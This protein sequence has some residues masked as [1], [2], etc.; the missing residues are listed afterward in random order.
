MRI[1]ITDT[2]IRDAVVIQTA[3]AI[4]RRRLEDKDLT[5]WNL[6]RYILDAVGCAM[7]GDE[8]DAI[9]REATERADYIQDTDVNW[10][11]WCYLGVLTA[12]W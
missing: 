11:T 3:R 7:T 12:S 2:E 8:V 4:L 6:D 9:A 5:A 1:D 10:Q